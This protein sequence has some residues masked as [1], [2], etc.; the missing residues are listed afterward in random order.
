M[1]SKKLIVIEII[2]YEI[3]FIRDIK[4]KHYRDM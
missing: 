3:Y 4:V 1:P 2:D